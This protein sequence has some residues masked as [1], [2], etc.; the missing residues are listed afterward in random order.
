MPA[1]GTAAPS[2]KGRGAPSAV[3][4]GGRMPQEGGRGCRRG[5]G[6]R[7]GG[8]EGGAAPPEAPFLFG[9]LFNS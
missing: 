8:R 4:G 1:P 3:Q 2:E 6:G 9:S 5:G 7:E